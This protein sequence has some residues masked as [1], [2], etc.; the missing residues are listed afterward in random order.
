MVLRP[1]GEQPPSVYWVRRGLLVGLVLL[2][3]ALI[4]WRWPSGAE[5]T[6]SSAPSPSPSVSPTDTA[7]ASPTPS[8][9]TKKPK[10][11]LEPECADSAIQ[12]TVAADSETYSAG[13]DPS[14]TF[15]VENVSEKACSRAVG[16]GA[17]ELRVTS[18]GAK[19]WSSDDCNPGGPADRS[20]LPP[21]DRF[22]QTVS[23][24]RVKS[25]EGCPTP[26][27]LADSG[28]YQVLARNIDLLSEPVAFE[29]Q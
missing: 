20:N 11:E 14:F 1:V 16:Q 8:K 25:A 17:N 21:G 22:V 24:E 7:S 9:T 28:T 12:V 6:E 27:E 26:E 18:G 29:L 10:E 19:V 4:W 15:T 5:T 2:V 3:A 13:R 23:W